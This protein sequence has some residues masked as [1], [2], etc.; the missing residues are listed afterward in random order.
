MVPNKISN[1]IFSI[2][3]MFKRYVNV[4]LIEKILSFQ[5]WQ[6][7]LTLSQ[8]VKIEIW[9]WAQTSMLKFYVDGLKV[10]QNQPYI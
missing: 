9:N 5:H 8:I 6:I 4:E 10:C 7:F 2:S 1:M 3:N